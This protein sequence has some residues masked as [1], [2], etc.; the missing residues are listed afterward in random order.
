MRCLRK[1]RPAKKMPHTAGSLT[2][3]LCLGL[4][5]PTVKGI[6]MDK[7]ASKKLCAD[8]ECL[9]ALS[10]A[11]AEDDYNAPD[12]RFI[13]IKKGQL[14]YVYAKLVKEKK[15]ENSG[16]EV[17]MENIMRTRWAPLVISRGV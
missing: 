15:L 9:Y 12:C 3:L 7:L 4:A 11:R 1:R 6:F 2:F 13:N 14:V 5:F 8:E 16:L 17:F 10:L